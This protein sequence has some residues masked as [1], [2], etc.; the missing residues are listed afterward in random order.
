MNKRNQDA[1]ASKHQMKVVFTAFSPAGAPRSP[2]GGRYFL[3]YDGLDKATSDRGG[4]NDV[5]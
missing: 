4:E 5:R 2:G 1:K 3:S